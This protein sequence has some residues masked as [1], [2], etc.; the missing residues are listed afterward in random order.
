MI[1][2][3]LEHQRQGSARERTADHAE[4]V[5]VDQRLVFGVER[6]EMGWAVVVRVH[7]DD[8]TVKDAQRRQGSP[9]QTVLKLVMPLVLKS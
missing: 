5:R 8:D 1:R 4:V 3:P 2:G 9:V 6:V 7:A